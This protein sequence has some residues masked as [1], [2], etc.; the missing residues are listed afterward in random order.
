MTDVWSSCTQKFI[1]RVCHQD[2]KGFAQNSPSARSCRC[3]EEERKEES[4]AHMLWPGCCSPLRCALMASPELGKHCGQS[5][6]HKEKTIINW[7]TNQPQAFLPLKD[8]PSVLAM[9]N[10]I[11]YPTAPVHREYNAKAFFSL[12]RKLLSYNN[13]LSYQ[14]YGV[15]SPKMQQQICK[16]CLDGSR[17]QRYFLPSVYL[18]Y[19]RAGHQRISV[20]FAHQSPRYPNSSL[21]KTTTLRLDLGLSKDNIATVERKQ[22]KKAPNTV[23][24][25]ANAFRF[26]FAICPLFIKTDIAI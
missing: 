7:N 24:S 26:L 8:N 18:S 22:Q 4:R 1:P 11:H 2:W 16:M 13:S 17:Q 14:V 5:H 25:P 10:C 19:L 23:W 20:T 12:S 9:W 6:A 15:F 3:Y 21:P